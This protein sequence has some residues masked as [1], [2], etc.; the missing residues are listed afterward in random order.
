MQCLVSAQKASNFVHLQQHFLYDSPVNTYSLRV[1]SRPCNAEVTE[2]KHDLKHVLTN[3]CYQLFWNRQFYA[4]LHKRTLLC[5][6]GM[7][8]QY[9]S[10]Q[11]CRTSDLHN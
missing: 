4:I 10:F 1:T 5:K 11:V 6:L 3:L 2:K 8:L 9:E 7:I